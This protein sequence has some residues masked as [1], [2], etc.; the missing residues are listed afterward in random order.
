MKYV[1]TEKRDND[2]YV[3]YDMDN[4]GSACVSKYTIKQIIEDNSSIVIGVTYS[5][6]KVGSNEVIIDKIVPY[7]K[8]GKAP[9]VKVVKNTFVPDT[10]RSFSTVIKGLKP[11]RA[12]IK[13]LNEKAKKTK[14]TKKA[15][16][17]AKKVAEE[18][19]LREKK[20]VEAEMKA[21]KEKFK[22]VKKRI[23]RSKP[24][25]YLK[26]IKIM[27]TEYDENVS[28]EFRAEC[29][30]PAAVTKLNNLIKS[31]RA[32]ADTRNAGD[33]IKRRGYFSTRL[34]CEGAYV[35][36][37]PDIQV[38]AEKEVW[39]DFDGSWENRCEIRFSL[40]NDYRPEFTY[41]HGTTFSDDSPFGADAYAD[42]TANGEARW[43][44]KHLGRPL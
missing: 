31:T 16:K 38:F 40:Y 26:K 13:A 34:D 36:D 41:T 3:I 43:L 5:Y 28:Y 39:L 4:K 37:D 24:Q 2:R 23:Q 21:E 10:K 15:N 29:L 8:D 9:A 22:V 42:H 18:T 1:I 11:S 35:L 7:T 30:T 14:A 32:Y 17:K 19:A 20:K 33:M 6:K 44:R 25:L 12:E 27:A